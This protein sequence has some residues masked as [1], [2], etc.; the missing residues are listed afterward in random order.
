M[1]DQ[2]VSG[3]PALSPA[4]GGRRW[5]SWRQVA[6]WV[7]IGAALGAL[8]WLILMAGASL[9]WF[10]IG[11]VIY[12]LLLPLVNR[13]A[14]A[15]PRWLAATIGVLLV[16]GLVVGGVALLVPPLL[17]ELQQL[18]A[19]LPSGTQLQQTY[20][21]AYGWYQAVVPAGVRSVVDS[22][23]SQL[24]AQAS[25]NLQGLLAEVSAR[26]AGV[27]Q[28]L[29]GL[30]VFLLG[31]II[32]LVWLYQLWSIRLSGRRLLHDVLPLPLRLDVLNLFRLFH[33]IFVSYLR[34]QVVLSLITSA[35]IWAALGVLNLLGYQIRSALLLAIVAGLARIVPYVGGIIG[36][37]PAVLLAL[38]AP[39]HPLQHALVVFAVYQVIYTIEGYLIDPRITGAAVSIPPAVLTPLVIMFGAAFGVVGVVLAAPV[40]ALARD[41]FLYTHRRLN[42]A[43]PRV[44]YRSLAPTQ[45]RSPTSAAAQERPGGKWWMPGPTIVD[46][47]RISKERGESSHGNE[48]TQSAQRPAEL[49]N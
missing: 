7:L 11:L 31:F 28:R 46:R 8:L 30:V 23:A 34:S 26:L 37:I 4:P 44:A 39:T 32:V 40:A 25:D 41:F 18:F 16:L 3:V 19:S 33:R 36:T 42:G 49:S 24:H 2:S 27:V 13:L 43:P 1:V 10:V 15:M 9:T 5:P 21:T 22:A 12:E 47:S 29:V 17:T 14:R 48:H 20:A 6:D 35:M 45:S 38:L